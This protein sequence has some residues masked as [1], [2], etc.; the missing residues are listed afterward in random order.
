MFYNSKFNQDISNW[1]INKRLPIDN[2][3]YVFNDCDIKN[4]FKP[5]MFRD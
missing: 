1:N 3:I 4:E 2:M 5:A